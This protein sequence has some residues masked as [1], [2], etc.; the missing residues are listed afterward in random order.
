MGTEE[1]TFDFREDIE[2]FLGGGKIHVQSKEKLI[3]Y[4][5]E[6]ISMTVYKNL[7][8]TGEMKIDK[9]TMT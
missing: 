6:M 7:G 9:C 2:N 8:R 5:I 3:S 1:E 4:Y